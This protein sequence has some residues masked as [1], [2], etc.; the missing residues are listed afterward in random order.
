ML[1]ELR[2][3]VKSPQAREHLERLSKALK[4]RDLDRWDRVP[5]KEEL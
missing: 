5:L 1:A 2:I 4:K 3:S